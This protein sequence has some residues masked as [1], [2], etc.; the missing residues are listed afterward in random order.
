MC[1][2]KNETKQ[3]ECDHLSVFLPSDA[4]NAHLKTIKAAVVV[5]QCG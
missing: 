1:R 5:S 4:P 3:T 2:L